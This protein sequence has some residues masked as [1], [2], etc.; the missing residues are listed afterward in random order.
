MQYKFKAVDDS[1]DI[2]SGKMQASSLGELESKLENQGLSLLSHSE[3]KTKIAKG[4]SLF[5]KVKPKDL[6]M[7]C[8]H[9][10]QLERAGV[11]LLEGLADVRDAVA[12]PLFRSVLSD[13]HDNVQSGEQLSA[14]LSKHTEIF[15]EVF[16][17]L[18]SVGERTGDL[19][20][21]FHHLQEHIKW[22][23]NFRSKVKKALRYPIFMFFIIIGIVTVMMTFVVPQIT[24]FLNTLKIELPFMT[25]ALIATSEFFQ[26]YGLIMLVLMVVTI[27]VCSVLYKISDPFR[28]YID[29]VTIKAPVFGN[30]IL[31]S[32]ISRFAHFFT[33]TYSSGVEILKCLE[34][35]KMVMSNM[36]LKEGVEDIITSVS[37]GETIASSMDRTG[38]FPNLV[39]RMFKVGEDSGNM[40]PALR[41]INE[42]YDREVEDSVDMMVGAIQPM[43]TM[44]IGLLLV[45]IILAV[46][47]P[48]YSNMTQMF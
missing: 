3:L 9:M 13:I 17:G 31:K 6:V 5:Y 24:E 1:G 19:A 18:V 38:L 43:L 36:V 28:Y 14:A 37:G 34:S 12:N 44:T 48:L 46:F 11:P 29:S 21:S 25:Q 26:N 45:W 22:T 30:M 23:D 7:M 15:D 10:E 33:I 39:L 47:G 40:E 27:M 8:V 20:R 42:F 35:A 4:S 2:M 16:I 41:N 32:N